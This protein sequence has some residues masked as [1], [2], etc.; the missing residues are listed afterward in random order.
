MG[1]AYLMGQKGGGEAKIKATITITF[2]AT[3][4]ANTLHLRTIDD[5]YNCKIDWG[6][7]IITDCPASGGNVVHNYTSAGMKTIKIAGDKFDS[8]HVSGQS[9]KEKYVTVEQA[10]EFVSQ[11]QSYD[12]SFEGCNNLT[13][14]TRELFKS[15]RDV[16]FNNCFNGCIK[17][18]AIPPKLFDNCPN[19]TGFSSCFAA[20]NIHPY[21]L[22]NSFVSIPA[23]LFDKCTKV[24]YFSSCF[25]GSTKV[26]TIPAGL[27][28]NCPKVTTFKACFENCCGLTA[29]PYGLFKNNTKVG[30][31][32]DCFNM[33]YTSDTPSRLASIPAGLF[34]N[35][36]EVTS[37]E[38]CFYY[39]K[40]VSIPTGL[41]KNNTKVTTFLRCFTETKIT[42]IPA[43]LFDNCPEVTEI[44]ECFMQCHELT[45]IP[46]GLF[47]NNR[48]INSFAYMFSWAKITSIPAGLFDNCPEAT[49][50]HGCFN[51]CEELTSVP[52]NLFKNNTKAI[53]FSSCFLNTYRL[54]VTSDI[55]GVDRN[56][57][58][59]V[60]VQINF[61]NC[62]DLYVAYMYTPS[63]TAPDLW[64]FSFKVTPKTNG[65]FRGHDT[66]TL[67]NYA[68]IPTAWRVYK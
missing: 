4:G 23:G 56:R 43:G 53:D 49:D 52:V 50:F 46:A 48:K 20:N 45:T 26:T 7:T 15:D 35:C 47:R 62:F 27:F 32:Q 36:P 10:G 64:N 38:C 39:A 5:G 51:Q 44:W 17:L 58:N 67:S 19:A 68:Q 28:D 42:S 63:G 3:V 9:G 55:F 34:D 54:R 25:E 41:F 22:Q 59:H 8:F 33:Y 40:I 6:D 60:A 61:G 29:I 24:L 31:F 12:R 13:T 21:S 30:T 18:A 66:R 11:P 65:C 16:S 14:V 1:T 57:F 2:A 37:F